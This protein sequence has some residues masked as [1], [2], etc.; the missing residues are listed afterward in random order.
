LIVN[1]LS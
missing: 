1:E